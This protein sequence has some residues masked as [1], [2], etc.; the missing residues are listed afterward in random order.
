MMKKLITTAS[1]ITGLVL[2]SPSWAL[3]ISGTL[4]DV[5]SVDTFIASTTLGNSGDATEKAWVDSVL[6]GDNTL[7][8]YDD[9]NGAGIGGS[10]FWSDVTDN[11]QIVDDTYA[12]KF[13]NGAQP[14]YYFLKLGVGQS[15]ADDHY[16]FKNLSEL[17]YAVVDFGSLDMGDLQFNI[18]RIS[19]IGGYG[20]TPPSV[21]EPSAS[22]LMGLGL[23]M[24][25]LMTRRRRKPQV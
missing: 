23:L 11:G 19:H 14:T 2:A 1:L 9:N 25:G 13:G 20:G 16:L 21:P 8:Y 24:M 5:G 4:T 6:G 10:Q 15:G 3:M 7:T 22:A 18:G 17:S 12:Y